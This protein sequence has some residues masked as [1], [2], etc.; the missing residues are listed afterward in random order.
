MHRILDEDG[1]PGETCLELVHGELCGPIAPATPR[2]N[3]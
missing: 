2:G 1:V 3:K